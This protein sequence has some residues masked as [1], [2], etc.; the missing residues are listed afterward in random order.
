MNSGRGGFDS[1]FVNFFSVHKICRTF[2]TSA[3]IMANGLFPAFK[4][5]SISNF[6]IIILPFKEVSFA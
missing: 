3:K 2:P 4:M 5:K 1:S 6:V